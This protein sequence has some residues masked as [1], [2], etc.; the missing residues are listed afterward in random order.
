MKHDWNGLHLDWR[1][2]L[3]ASSLNILNDFGVDF[4]FLLKL[5]KRGNWVRKVCSLNINPV[6]ISK[7]VYLKGKR[8]TLSLVCLLTLS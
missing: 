7:T 8:H 6:L 3:E 2:N 4:V 5:I 1:W